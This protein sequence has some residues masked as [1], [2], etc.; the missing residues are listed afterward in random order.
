MKNVF[1]IGALSLALIASVFLLNTTNADTG[2]LQLQIT[3]GTGSCQYGTSLDLG[4]KQASY[5]A[6]TFTGDFPA[7]FRCEDNQGTQAT[8]QLTMASSVLTNASNSA[9]T[10]PATGVEMM[11][12]PTHVTAGDCDRNTGTISYTAIDSTQPI[13]GKVNDQG[14]V[15]KVQADTV[16]LKVTT[17]TN[18]AVGIYTGT[19]TVDVPSFLLP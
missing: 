6:L 9:Y 19:L 4:T 12:T 13:L 5:S 1:K 11:N 17:A 15:C 3:A 8:W 16:S 7:A 14:A 2:V 18:Q 10:I